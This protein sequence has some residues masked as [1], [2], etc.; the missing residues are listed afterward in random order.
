MKGISFRLLDTGN[1]RY[2]IVKLC[3]LQSYPLGAAHTMPVGN[4][5]DL[6]PSLGLPPKH[7]VQLGVD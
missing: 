2:N 5:A 7:T 6:D 4:L 3:R 1:L